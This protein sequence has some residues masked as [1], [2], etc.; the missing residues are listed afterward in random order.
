ML[1]LRSASLCVVVVDAATLAHPPRHHYHHLD[2][3]TTLNP[4]PKQPRVDGNLINRLRRADRS[5]P[6]RR[7]GA[8]RRAGRGA[9]IFAQP[10]VIV[11]RFRSRRFAA[12]AAAAI[13]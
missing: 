8:R 1:P 12:A 4:A 10:V 7:L 2:P 13:D 6:D 3:T 9:P 11:R 5:I